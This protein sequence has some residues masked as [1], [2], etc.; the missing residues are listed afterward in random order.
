MLL[1][2]T[3]SKIGVDGMGIV[4]GNHH[5][6][7]GESGILAMASRQAMEYRC[8]E[9]SVRAGGRNTAHFFVI[10]ANQQCTHGTVALQHGLQAGKTTEQV[11][12]TRR[13]NKFPAQPSSD[14]AWVS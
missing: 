1:V 3:V 14:G 2:M 7:L 11:V 10:I 9:R 5:G 8:Q 13:G 12:Q 6:P 4:C